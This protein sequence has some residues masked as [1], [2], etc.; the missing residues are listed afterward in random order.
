MEHASR[1]PRTPCRS[2]RKIG[3]L[4]RRAPQTG[5]H[6]LADLARDSGG[7]AG[8]EGSTSRCTVRRRGRPQGPGASCCA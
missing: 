1:V 8:I 5:L 2:D 7:R 4:A 3:S 6:H